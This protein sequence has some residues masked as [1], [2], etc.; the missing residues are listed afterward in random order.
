M[1]DYYFEIANLTNNNQ[2]MR[3]E[4]L[5]NKSNDSHQEFVKSQSRNNQLLFDCL[6]NAIAICQI[7]I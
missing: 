6:V 3:N 5:I 7:D 2:K 4:R 1:C